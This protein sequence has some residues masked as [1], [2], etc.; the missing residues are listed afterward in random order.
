MWFNV[1][2]VAYSSFSGLSFDPFEYSRAVYAKLY[3]S[4][5]NQSLSVHPKEIVTIRL[6]TAKNESIVEDGLH[7]RVYSVLK[8]QNFGGLY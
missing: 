6:F 8:E 2:F 1:R 3:V 7:E 5:E 4:M